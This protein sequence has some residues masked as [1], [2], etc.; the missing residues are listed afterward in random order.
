MNKKK[1][2]QKFVQNI[3]DLK[4]CVEHVFRYI[5]RG[6]TVSVYF[7]ASDRINYRQRANDFLPKNILFVVEH[8]N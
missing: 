5:F 1:K 7:A 2:K 6:E 8:L 3:L 4:F